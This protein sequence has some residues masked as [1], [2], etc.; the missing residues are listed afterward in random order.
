MCCYG[1]DLGA[2]IV[3]FNQSRPMRVLHSA[4]DPSLPSLVSEPQLSGPDV[5]LSVLDLS[6]NLIMAIDEAALAGRQAP[7]VVGRLVHWEQHYIQ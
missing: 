3:R 2:S 7:L 5:Q 4:L 1:I 6:R